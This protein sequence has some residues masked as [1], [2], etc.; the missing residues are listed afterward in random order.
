[1]MAINYKE[2]LNS[3]MQALGIK[4]SEIGGGTGKQGLFTNFK[5]K[6]QIREMQRRNNIPLMVD[7]QAIE[8]QRRR[9]LMDKSKGTGRQSTMLGAL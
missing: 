2:M 9:I 1:M 5:K 3:Q 7:E 6:G 8:E 4:P